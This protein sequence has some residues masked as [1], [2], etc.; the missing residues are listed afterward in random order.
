MKIFSP[1]PSEY[2]LP[3]TIGC[4]NHDPRKEKLPC[5]SFG[6]RFETKYE[7]LGPGPAQYT[8]ENCTRYGKVHYR[9]QTTRNLNLSN[10]VIATKASR[11]SESNS[12]ARKVL[13]TKAESE[14]SKKKSVSSN[15]RNPTNRNKPKTTKKTVSKGY[16]NESE[17][18][19]ENL[20]NKLACVSVQVVSQF[21]S[22]Y[23]QSQNRPLKRSL[24]HK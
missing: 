23:M 9:Q 14:G 17:Y 1:G 20:L 5:Y 2:I 24:K 8:I 7:T 19:L 22:L 16:C 12:N 13:K 4:R 21:M 18:I 11:K 6:R 15:Q 10:K 3:S